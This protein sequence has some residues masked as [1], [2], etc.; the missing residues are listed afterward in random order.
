MGKKA[1]NNKKPKKG[2]EDAS[3]TPGGGQAKPLKVCGPESVQ[4]LRGQLFGREV[5]LICCGEAHEDAIDLTRKNC[6]PEAEEGWVQLPL[7]TASGFDPEEEMAAQEGLTLEAA[8]K[9]AERILNK[10]ADDDDSDSE[11]EDDG[12]FLVF[13]PQG[14]GP[15][16][17]GIAR[18]F[19]PGLER[20][21]EHKL[22]ANAV[23]LEWAD[24]DDQAREFNARRLAG[25]NVPHAEHDALIA[26]RKRAR[27]A[28]GV[29][30]FDDWLAR[31]AGST[32]ARVEVL[33]EGPVLAS[34]VEL[35][36]EPGV[37]P[38]PLAPGCF[39]DMELDS[40]A[41]SED[42][43]DPDD[44][45]GSFIDY[46]R[47]RLVEQLPGEQLRGFDP[48]DLGD[49]QDA[50]LQES[51]RALLKGPLPE[52]PEAAELEALGADWAEEPDSGSE[53]G[54]EAS[55]AP[56]PRPVP[57]WEAY[58]GAA[59]ELLYYSPQVKADFAPLLARCIRSAA[60]MRRFFEALYF[61]TVPEALAAVQLGGEA[62]PFT[63][64]RSAAYRPPERG[65]ALL[66]RPCVQRLVPIR[67]APL[68]CYLKARGSDPPRTWVSGLAERL[69]NA[70]AGD[71]VA[72]AQKWFKD[73]VE[74]LLTDP[75]NADDEGDYFAAWLRACHRDIY[76]DV[77]RSDPEELRR[78][79]WAPSEAHPKSKKHRHRL[80]D[81]DIPDFDAAFQE[82]SKLNAAQRVSTARERV[83]AKILVDAFQLRLVD[84][85]ATLCVADAVMAAPSGTRVVVVMYAGADH[86][87][88]VAD[89]WRARGFSHK[90]LPQ[91]GYVG[92]EGWEDDE[93]R[94]LAWP[95]YL[96]NFDELFPVR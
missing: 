41:D 77:D 67:V 25:E 91:K 53:E 28:E 48:R 60:G 24:L 88:C 85:A 11:E 76:D 93:P 49:A 19:P 46:L 47:R 90:G 74:C 87:K 40:D 73:S 29:E 3:A 18:V 63:Y 22:P 16:A 54:G 6:V 20:S 1:G 36:V 12:G 52:D 83:L 62:R 59:A 69:K 72:A 70:G 96:H 79:D 80:K 38:P 55:L 42:E 65:A 89:F 14:S 81:I 64:L 57:S 66:R 43:E 9:W 75:K 2:E 82:L 37:G 45:T 32:A 58:F 94:G 21:A 84:L 71:I 56:R 5:A 31:Q 39:R 23:L 68:D 8:K 30:L 95:S 34:E 35:H 86:T 26:E 4:T 50:A 61:K 92:K 7:G 13:E 15:K 10:A 33:L 17:K 44:G 27:L 51:F 78:L